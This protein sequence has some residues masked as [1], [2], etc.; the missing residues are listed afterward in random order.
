MAERPEFSVTS[1]GLKFE[2]LLK[3]R[4]PSTVGYFTELYPLSL[5]CN[6][7]DLN[8]QLVVFLQQYNH[9]AF[10]RY[11]YRGSKNDKDVISCVAR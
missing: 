5:N 1:R 3:L 2:I 10:F 8:R 7:C 11:Y 6:L 4:V 9:E